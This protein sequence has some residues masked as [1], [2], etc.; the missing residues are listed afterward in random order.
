M[1]IQEF[2]NLFYY[3]SNIFYGSAIFVYLFIIINSIIFINI[4]KSIC[5][6]V[7]KNIFICSITFILM[8]F[9]AGGRMAVFYIFFF[10][11]CG[12]L[13]KGKIKTKYRKNGFIIAVITIVFLL[14]AFITLTASRILEN[15]KSFFEFL[16]QY[17]VGPSFLYDYEINKGYVNSLISRKLSAAVASVDW[18]VVGILKLFGFRLETILVEWNSALATGRY[19][20]RDYGIN[21][22]YTG[23]LF[24]ELAFGTIF[25]VLLPIFFWMMIQFYSRLSP[26]LTLYFCFMIFILNRENLMNSPTFI[27]VFLYFN[28]EIYKGR[29]KW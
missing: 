29:L 13:I 6:G 26:E 3:G 14:V 21:A 4:L 9:A 17:L 11:L 22:H 5:S 27:L 18:L 28:Y 19:L 7:Y 1:T 24:F 8:D 12:I 23:Y 15:E 16:Y 10:L 25:V 2:R 20:N